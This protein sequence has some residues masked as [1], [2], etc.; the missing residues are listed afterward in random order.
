MKRLSG[1]EHCAAGEAR[2]FAPERLDGGLPEPTSP[3]DFAEGTVAA[4]PFPGHS[5][6]SA[7]LCL[8]GK[9]GQGLPESFGLDGLAA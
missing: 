6:T 2:E 7:F 4:T 8:A 5:F 1:A 3:P 9:S